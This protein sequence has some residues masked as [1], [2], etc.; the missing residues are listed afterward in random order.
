MRRTVGL[1]ILLGAALGCGETKTPARE[2]SCEARSVC[3]DL[4]GPTPGELGHCAE[5]LADPSCGPA[6]ALALA[7]VQQHEAC[8][9]DGRRD[10]AMTED[11]CAKQVAAALVTPACQAI[12]NQDA[13]ATDDATAP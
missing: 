1:C 8:T 3:G 13:G 9:T 11:A 12:L 2:G 5:A 10:V 7:C 6:Y 4:A